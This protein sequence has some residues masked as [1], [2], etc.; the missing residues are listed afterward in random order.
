MALTA[1]MQEQVD[2]QRAAEEARIEAN[3]ATHSQHQKMEA[4]RIAQNVIFE[5]RRVKLASEVT[6]VTA[7]DVTSLAESLLTFIN[8]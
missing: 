7:S 4:V 2:F 1:E 6:D 5:N 8:S 3:A